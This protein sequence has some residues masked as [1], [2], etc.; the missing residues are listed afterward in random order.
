MY[1]DPKNDGHCSRWRRE[2]AEEA[3]E[4]VRELMEEYADV[5]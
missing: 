4:K 3:R 1:P 2:T 5:A